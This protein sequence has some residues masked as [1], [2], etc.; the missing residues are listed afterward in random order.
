M[1]DI[2]LTMVIW[3]GGI[4]VAL[5]FIVLLLTVI[6]EFLLNRDPMSLL[7]GFWGFWMVVGILLI[8][9]GQL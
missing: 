3:G 7:V 6:E 2:G 8:V 4:A 5:C 1:T 9:A